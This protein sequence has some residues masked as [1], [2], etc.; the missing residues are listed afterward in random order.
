MG[1]GGRLIEFRIQYEALVDGEWRAIV[2]YDT[3]HGF[4]HK[5]TLH[6]DGTQT[7]DFYPNNT[8]TEVLTLGQRDITENWRTYR[9]KYEQEMTA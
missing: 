6:P 8:V 2:R 9:A 5:D 1:E 7:K 4:A 3:A